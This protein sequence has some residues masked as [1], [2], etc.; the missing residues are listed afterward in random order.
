MAPS[1]L[2]VLAIWGQT[3]DY[4]T[5]LRQG[6]AEYSNGKF[7]AAERLFLEALSQL[8]PAD[9]LER[10][11]TLGDLSAAYARQAQ[12][13]KA[14]HAYLECLSIYRRLSDK[15]GAALTLNSLGLLYS[16][17]GRDEDALRL[18]TEAL[19]LIKHAPENNVSLHAQVLN[20]IGIIHY[21]RGNNGKAE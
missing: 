2:L 18:L 1:V 10:A 20:G 9:Q 17:Q 16:Q 6:R 3:A 11:R 15:N 8:N 4:P 12:L 5:L 7:A 19:D 21:R 14:E 13:S